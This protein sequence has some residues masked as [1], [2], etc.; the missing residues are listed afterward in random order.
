MRKKIIIVFIIVI[1]GVYAYSF[2]KDNNPYNYQIIENYH[3]GNFDYSKRGYYFEKVDNSYYYVITL[4][5][6]KTGYHLE[7]ESLDVDYYGN[8][9]VVI[10]E[11]APEDND[12]VSMNYTFPSIAIKFNKEV[13]GINVKNVDGGAYILLN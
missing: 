4:G 3:S 5:E 11:T 1:I 12:F 6:G 8:V 13:H 9:S 10:K 7:I 2:Y